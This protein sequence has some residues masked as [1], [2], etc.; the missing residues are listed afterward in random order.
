MSSTLYS[1]FVIIGDRQLIFTFSA[2]FI[3]VFYHFS[4]VFSFFLYE[5]NKSHVFLAIRTPLLSLKHSVFQNSRCN[6]E[7][8]PLEVEGSKIKDVSMQLY[9]AF[10]III[11]M[12]HSVVGTTK[13]VGKHPLSFI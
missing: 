10:K 9:L 3:T 5:K 11:Y 2:M 12:H 13:E 1:P 4:K 8:G 6:Y 7:S